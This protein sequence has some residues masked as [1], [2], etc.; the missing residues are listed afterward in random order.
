MKNLKIT[1]LSL[2]SFL[3]L[4]GIQNTF[5]QIDRIEK[6]RAKAM[7]RNV[8]N[9]IEDNYY[10]SNYKGLDLKAKE[11]AAMERIGKSKTLGEAFGIIAQVLL[12]FEDSHT[13]FVPPSR[14]VKIEYGW[15][16]QMIGDKAFIYAVKPKSDAHKKGLRTGDMIISVNGF[17][18]TRK[19]LWKINYYYYSINPQT[20]MQLVVQSPDGKNKT[21][22]I[23]T[24]IKK[25]KRVVDLT[26]SIDFSDFL[27]ELSE[28]NESLSHRFIKKNNVVVWRMSTFSFLPQQ[29]GD[30]IDDRVKGT[31][32]LILDLRR[33]GGGYVKTLEELAGHMFEKKTKIADIK[34]R[35]KTEESFADPKGKEIYKGR[36]IV[37]V[38]S[39]SG[40]AS[41][42]FAG[43][44][45]IEGRGKVLGDVSAGAVMQ[46]RFHSKSMGVNKLVSYG[47]SV[48]NADVIM[49]DGKSLEKVG[50]IPNE[51]ILVTGDDLANERDPVLARAFELLGVKTT[52]EEVGK[53]FPFYWADGKKGNVTAKNP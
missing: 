12:D 13:F 47:A 33:N 34:S 5:A 37:L 39:Q 42:I 18:P 4:F 15:K 49:T 40:S 26:Q 22:V 41:E 50:V 36:I 46:S 24:K 7:L 31:S 11:K 21:L 10:D 19:D 48:T 16:M 1:V 9:D 38:D 2:F 6:D 8:V 43:L 23:N 32:A 27:R 29:V 17:R 30:I 28:D 25:T 52:A 14:P 3:I 44:M 53:H 51:R 20:K 45:Q 35:K